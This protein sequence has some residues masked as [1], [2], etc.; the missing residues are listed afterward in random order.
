LS[1]K[2]FI[3]YGWDYTANEQRTNV[4]FTKEGNSQYVN[5]KTLSPEFASRFGGRDYRWVNVVNLSTYGSENIAT[6]LPFNMFDREWPRLAISES[7]IIGSEGW[8][9]GQKHKN[10]T[11]LLELLTNENAIIGALNRLGVE[12][13]LS[14]PGHIAKQILEHIGGVRGISLIAEQETLQ[15][16]N[17]MAGAVRIKSNDNDTIEET[18]ELRSSA[19]KQWY[20]LIAKRKKKTLYR[21]E[22]EDFTKR[23]IIRLGIETGCPN[24]QFTNWHSLSAT[25]YKLPCERCLYVYDFPQASITEK[26]RW[27]YRVVGPFSIPDYAKGSYSALLT[28]RQFQEFSGINE[29]M[30]FSMALSLKFNEI[31][32]ETD[33]VALKKNDMFGANKQP[34]LIIGEAKSF[35]VGD[36]IKDKDIIKLKA[37]G[38]KLPGAIIVIS[39]LRDKFTPTEKKD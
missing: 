24:C 38:Q 2:R 35:G 4:N 29:E 13:R 1:F 17:K 32:A 20:S 21:L 12:A 7:V 23:N 26:G 11:D 39:I 3:N 27:T 16:L 37:L 19:T 10:W 14:E 5:Y 18:F 34:E 36:L 31:E 33:F 9:F 15:L 6:I 28:V 8:V 22:L 30:T 25:D